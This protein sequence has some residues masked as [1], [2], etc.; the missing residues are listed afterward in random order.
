MRD[1]VNSN[2][3]IVRRP[4]LH[5]GTLALLISRLLLVCVTFTVYTAAPYALLEASANTCNSVCSYKT[6]RGKVNSVT[7]RRSTRISYITLT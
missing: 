3:G 1:A 7:R 4:S 2:L 5:G 6:C